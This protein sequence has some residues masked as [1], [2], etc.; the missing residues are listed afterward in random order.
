MIWTGQSPARARNHRESGGP[1]LIELFPLFIAVSVFLASA[2]ILTK[3]Y[4]QS[5]MVWIVSGVLGAVSWG[6]YALI[7]L[8]LRRK[9]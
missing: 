9:L 2:A 6:L 5:D 4:G 7:I 1:T 3:H 8:K